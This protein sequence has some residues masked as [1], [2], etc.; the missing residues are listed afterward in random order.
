MIKV[1]EKFSKEQEILTWL[2]QND[3]NCASNSYSISDD[4]I[5]DVEGDVD[6]MRKELTSIP[7]QFGEVSG[8]FKCSVNQ[9]TSLRGCPSSVGGSFLC[10]NNQLTSL[11]GCPSTV[12]GNFWC[13]DNQ[14]TSLQYAPSS[15]G[16][17]FGCS[18]NKLPNLQYA[19]ASVGGA[20]DC[21]KNELN[22]LQGCPST[23]G[24]YFDCS[25]NKL[26]S[27]KYAPSSVGEWF[28]CFDN[29]FHNLGDL[30]GIPKFIGGDAFG[31]YFKSDIPEVDIFG[32][33]LVGDII[34]PNYGE[35]EAMD[36]LYE[37]SGKKY[38]QPNA[39]KKFLRQE[40]P[41]YLSKVNLKEIESKF[42]ELGY[43]II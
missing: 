16:G 10:S 29:Q 32:Y 26:T 27:L 18:N 19:P 12:G 39:L 40:S 5:I 42:K 25:N 7:Y 2:E 24:G 33:K 38:Y 28:W 20:F 3:K 1:F 31:G 23:V 14:L 13:G 22:S 34:A 35:F 37:E 30:V 9:L 43:E 15:V 21:S 17:S 4:G 36:V 6:I 11:Q 8:Y 41:S